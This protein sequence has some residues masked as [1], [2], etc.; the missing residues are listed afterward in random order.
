MKGKGISPGAPHGARAHEWESAR[1]KQKVYEWRRGAG[2]AGRKSAGA[3][4]VG[5]ERKG[6]RAVLKG[7]MNHK[8]HAHENKTNDESKGRPSQRGGGRIVR[9]G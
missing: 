4:P 1:D 8:D 9:P 7:N 3:G 2:A 6:K 5:E